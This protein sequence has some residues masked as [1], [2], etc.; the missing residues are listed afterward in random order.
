MRNP[1]T[2]LLLG[3]AE[4]AAVD[5]ANGAHDGFAIRAMIGRR[6]GIAN[7]PGGFDIILEGGEVGHGFA[8]H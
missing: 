5:Q 2:V 8:H 3:D 7:L 1:L 4:A 6:Q